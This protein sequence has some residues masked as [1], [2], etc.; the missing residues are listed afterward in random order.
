M[1]VCNYMALG[2]GLSSVVGLFVG[3]VG[4]KQSCNQGPKGLIF[5]RSLGVTL[6]RRQPLLGKLSM[7]YDIS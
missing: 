4:I 3:M 2:L 5:M 7:F 6:L 1:Y